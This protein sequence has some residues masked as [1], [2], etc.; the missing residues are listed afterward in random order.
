MADSPP[1][2]AAD[3]TNAAYCG[4]T[5]L[6]DGAGN[7]ATCQINRKTRKIAADSSTDFQRKAESFIPLPPSD[8]ET[9]YIRLRRS[10]IE[11]LAHDHHLLALARNRH[12]QFLHEARGICGKEYFTSDARIIDFTVDLAPALHLSQDPHRER[13]VRERV[14]IDTVRV[15]AHLTQAVGIRARQH[16]LHHRHR[17]VQIIGR[18][19]GSCN[20]LA[21]LALCRIRGGI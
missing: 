3:P 4:S 8:R 1:E 19:N 7:V 10:R 5:L 6:V 16:L 15:L 20:L 14:E 17:L 13:L 11:C 2:A 9:A 21:I 12:V 18:R